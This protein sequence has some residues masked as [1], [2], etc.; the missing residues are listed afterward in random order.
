MEADRQ[1]PAQPPDQP[2]P[3]AQ[4]A[5]R[6]GPKKGTLA[7]IVGIPAAALLLTFTP[8]EESGRQVEATVAADGQA[9]VRHVS[10]KQYLQAYLDIVKVPTAC[11]GITK[12]VKLGQAYTEAQCTA[13]LERELVI[14]AQGVQRCTPR[15]WEPGREQ[16]R[17]AAILLA[18]NIGVG[19]YCTSS[20]DRAFDAASWRTGCDAFLKWNKAGGRVV[21]G[22]TARRK[23]ERAICLKG[24]PPPD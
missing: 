5:E 24:L 10:G 20:I 1:D 17:V 12:G 9:T 11:D 2:D 7:F 3:A 4:P 6:S 15:L 23:R 19:G 18:Y 8:A 22:L 13:M 21:A 14:H 16:Q